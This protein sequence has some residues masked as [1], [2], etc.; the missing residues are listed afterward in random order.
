[1]LLTFLGHAGIQI[2]A[3]NRIVY[4]DPHIDPF[5]LRNCKKADLILISTADF[6]HFSIECVRNLI[7][8][9]GFMCGTTEAAALLHGVSPLRQN[10]IRDFEFCT[11]KAMPTKPWGRKR[12]NSIIGFLL[13]IEGKRI[14]FT[15][16]TQYVPEMNMLK[17]DVLLL[18]VGGTYSPTAREASQWLRFIE[19]KL[20]IPIHYGRLDGT[21]DDANELVTLVQHP[22]Q[23]RIRILRENQTIDVDEVMKSI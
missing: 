9:L 23:Q 16:D 2:L 8:D 5:L 14:Y 17:P 3:N 7:G 18:P 22:L 15:G 6:D 1:M 11:V 4:I 12:A 20:V 21:I 19:P 10:E 13:E